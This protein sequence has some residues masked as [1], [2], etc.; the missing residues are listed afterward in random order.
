MITFLPIAGYEG[1]YEVGNDGS[2]RSVD[3][4]VTRN[5]PKKNIHT[6]V[7]KGR[8]LKRAFYS[9][10]YAF[11]GLSKEGI[12]KQYLIHRLV[13]KAFLSGNH[14]LQVNHINGNKKDNRV[15]NLEWCTG[16]ENRIHAIKTGLQN[17]FGGN[18][19][20]ARNI[21]LEKNGIILS[22]STQREAAKQ[23]GAKEVTLSAA[24]K[25]NRNINGY[26]II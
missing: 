2:V 17:P 1:L 12:I 3:R 9:N 10:G 11:V 18:N 8:V 13:A 5:N 7:Q 16:Q 6:M 25:Y 19:G 21:Q 14:L 26:K 20:Y 24:R 4:I 23:I 15:E 22:F